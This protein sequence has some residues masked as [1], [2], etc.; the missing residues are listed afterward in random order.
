MAG[1]VAVCVVIGRCYAEAADR[2]PREVAAVAIVSAARRS[3]WRYGGGMV[4]RSPSRRIPPRREPAARQELR[5]EESATPAGL[6][7]RLGL[8]F[9]AMAM[10]ALPIAYQWT[11]RPASRPPGSDLLVQ[12]LEVGGVLAA[13][14]GLLLGRQARAGGDR[15]TGAVWAPRLGGG[16]I[17]GYAMTLVVAISRGA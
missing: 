15:S 12:L 17:V 8:A 16:A 11:F 7:A 9:G 14:V 2:S 1:R 13:A 5:P 6:Q 4:K 3:A 10:I